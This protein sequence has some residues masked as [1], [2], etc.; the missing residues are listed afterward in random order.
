M[1]RRAL[2]KALGLAPAAG[3]AIADAAATSAPPLPKVGA[4]LALIDMPLINGGDFKASEAQ[5]QVVL[6]YWWASWCPFCAIQTPSMQKLW[7][8]QRP[9]GLQMLGL[10]IDRDVEAPRRY[11]AQKGYT[12]P[13]GIVGPQAGSAL[14]KPGDGLPVTCVRGRDG[15]V[16]F[17]ESGQMFPEDIADLARF[18]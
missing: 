9:R 13:S 17:V 18:V 8:A 15:R 1:R 3:T 4:P 7:D 10:S 14:A 6:L 2:L 16:A 12:F 5:G 11:M